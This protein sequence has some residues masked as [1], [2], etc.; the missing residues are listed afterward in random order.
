MRDPPPRPTASVTVTTP[1]DLGALVREGRQ[2][3]GWTQTELGARIGASRFWVA[4]F[5]HGKSRAELGLALRAIA[6]VGIRL[7]AARPVV[8]TG[9]AAPAA[10]AG[11]GR[12]DPGRA[13]G[14]NLDD[15]VG[16]GAGFHVA[17]PR[18]RHARRRG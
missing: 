14:V 4:E 2:R 6:A 15:V 18:A 11:R 7:R 10:D 9:T 13:A 8:A 16:A 1:T 3:R 5:E 17:P 12:A